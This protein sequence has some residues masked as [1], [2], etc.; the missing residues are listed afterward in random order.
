MLSVKFEKL[1]LCAL[2]PEFRNNK[3]HLFCSKATTIPAYNVANIP[4]DIKLTIP[5]G[6]GCRLIPCPHIFQKWK[7]LIFENTYTNGKI[8]IFAWNLTE[9][10]ILFP[11]AFQL[12][13][14][15]F[16]PTTFIPVVPHLTNNHELLSLVENGD[17]FPHNTLTSNCI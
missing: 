6:Y 4:T 2:E 13:Y 17:Y 8:N 14:L 10:D 1:D 9:R 3:Y 7:I 11:F 16:Y 12:V 15:E 5:Q